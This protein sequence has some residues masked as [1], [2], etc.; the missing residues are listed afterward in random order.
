L[1]SEETKKNELMLI[2]LLSSAQSGRRRSASSILGTYVCTFRGRYPYTSRPTLRPQL[3]SSLATRPHL[4]PLLSPSVPRG[5]HYFRETTAA[6]KSDHAKT[7]SGLAP[8]PQSLTVG[9][10]KPTSPRR[11]LALAG[12]GHWGSSPT[13]PLPEQ[14][15][16]EDRSAHAEGAIPPFFLVAT[17]AVVD[18]CSPAVSL[19]SRT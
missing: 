9:H 12:I 5:T 13:C 8:A 6:G 1:E 14:A 18:L 17:M 16:A 19:S 4:L 3:P 15:V 10:L 7:L 11:Q 2:H